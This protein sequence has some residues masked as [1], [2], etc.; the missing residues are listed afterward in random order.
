MSKYMDS[1]IGDVRSWVET[2]CCAESDRKAGELYAAYLNWPLSSQSRSPPTDKAFGRAL[3]ALGYSRRKT[4]GQ[5]FY[6][7]LDL[8]HP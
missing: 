5:Q 8:R 2:Q 6:I 7:N 3:T 1:V 4:G